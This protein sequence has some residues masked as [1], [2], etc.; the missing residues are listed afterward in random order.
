VNVRGPDGTFLELTPEDLAAAADALAREI[1]PIEGRQI[2]VLSTD[3]NDPATRAVLSWA[4]VHGAAL[5]LEPERETVLGTAVWARPTVFLGSIDEIARLRRAA[6]N[7]GTGWLR[8]LRSPKQPRRPLGRL[9]TVLSTEPG[10]LSPEDES[11][12]RDRGVR[13]RFLPQCGIAWY[14]Q[15]GGDRHA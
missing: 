7:Q 2:L 1:V 10:P 13:V 9:R 6:E 15:S 4:T 11:F 8:R 5:L 12:W 14:I 3:R